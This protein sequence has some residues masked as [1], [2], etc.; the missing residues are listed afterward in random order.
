[1]RRIAL[2][3][4]CTMLLSCNT[5]YLISTQSA[6]SFRPTANLNDT[7]YIMPYDYFIVSKKPVYE[8]SYIQY[9]YQTG[10]I[11]RNVITSNSKRISKKRYDQLYGKNFSLYYSRSVSYKRKPIETAGPSTSSGNSTRT[12]RSGSSS[13]SSYTPSGRAVNVKGYYRKDG[14]YVRPHTRRA[15]GRR[16]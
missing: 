15:P 2:L 14:T 4:A 7:L 11:K 3:M 8:G 1:M 6:I 9:G 5:Y 12:Y 13:N 10:Y 16:N